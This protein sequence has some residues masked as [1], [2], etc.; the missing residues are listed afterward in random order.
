MFGINRTNC[1]PKFHVGQQFSFPIKKIV[2]ALG[3]FFEIEP[4]FDALLHVSKVPGGDL[5]AFAVGQVCDVRI[6]EIDSRGR[7][8]LG[9]ADAVAHPRSPFVP[10]DPTAVWQR[11]HPAEDSAAVAWLREVTQQA[12]I[13]ATLLAEL[14][15]RFGVPAPFAAWMRLHPEFLNLGPINQ[16][17]AH[18]CCGLAARVQDPGYWRMP[19][20]TLPP[21]VKTGVGSIPQRSTARPSTTPMPM[22]TMGGIKQ[23]QSATYRAPADHGHILIDGSNL[24]RTLSSRGRAL[25]ALLGELNRTGMQFNL[26]FDATI[27]YVLED[28]KDADGLQILSNFAKC[29]TIVPAGTPADDYLLLLADRKGW[30]VLSNDRFEAYRDRYPWL[31]ERVESKTRRLHAVAEVGDQLVAP[32]L[33]LIADLRLPPGVRW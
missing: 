9:F 22:S 19:I 27:K 4:G 33:G 10:D 16:F 24:I 18:P 23:A 17:S 11:L 25:A 28:S 21:S 30:Q 7:V 31:A 8:Q 26:L 15:T 5:S 2:P 29:T 1:A 14:R 6:I 3:M 20:R 12:P 13:H 32:T